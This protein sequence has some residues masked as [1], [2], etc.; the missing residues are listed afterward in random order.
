MKNFI[1]IQTNSI[2]PIYTPRGLTYMLMPV[3]VVEC[4]IF[5]KDPL[6]ADGGSFKVTTL[7]LN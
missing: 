6:D 1:E 3:S 4:F 2:H 5:Y 7:C